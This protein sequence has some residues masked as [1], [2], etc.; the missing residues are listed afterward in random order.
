MDVWTAMSDTSPIYCGDPHVSVLDLYYL[1]DIIFHYGLQYM[2]YADATQLP[3][4]C[5]GDQV[6][7]GTIKEYVGEI[8]NWMRTNM[9]TLNER[10]TEVIHFSRKF[11]GQ[12]PVP[13]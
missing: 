3:I 7:T 4:T 11:Y 13:S 12:G 2:M 1:E 10:K 8:R 6:P 9:L 5:D